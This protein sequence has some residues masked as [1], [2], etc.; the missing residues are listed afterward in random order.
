MVEKRGNMDW[1]EERAQ[2]SE[3]VCEKRV[4]SRSKR[5]S[6]GGLVEG[7]VDILEDVGWVSDRIGIGIGSEKYWVYVKSSCE[8]KKQYIC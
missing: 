2:I 8:K 5:M 7:E 3:C 6:F 1:I 4:L